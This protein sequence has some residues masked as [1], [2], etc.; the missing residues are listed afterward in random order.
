[1]VPVEIEDRGRGLL[2]GSPGHIDDRPLMTGAEAPREGNL[3][4]DGVREALDPRTYDYGRRFEK[5]GCNLLRGGGG[6]ARGD[7]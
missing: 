4:G 1:M 3:L 7:A 5:D 6:V 2:D